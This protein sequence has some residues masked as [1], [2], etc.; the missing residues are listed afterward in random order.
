M[1]QKLLFPNHPAFGGNRLRCSTKWFI[2]G[3][4]VCFAV[5]ANHASAVPGD[6]HWDRQFGMAGNGTINRALRCNGNWLY[7]GGFSV[8]FGGQISSNTVVNVFNGTNW[9]ILGEFSGSTSAILDF[10]FLGSNVYVGGIFTQAG[11]VPAVGLAKWDGA[12]WSDVGGFSGMVQTMTTD[13]TNIYVGGWFTNAGGVHVINVARWNGTNW[14]ALGGGLGSYDDSSFPTVNVLIWRKG[15]LYAGGA[16]ASAGAVAATNLACWDGSAWSQVGG[17]VPGVGDWL[18]GSPVTTLQ[19]LDDD[20]YAGGNFTAVGANVPALHVAKWNG[21]TWSAL[22]TGL[23][24]SSTAPPVTEL[25]FL[26]TNLYAT[27]NF[28]NAGGITATH[29][30]KWNGSAWSSI[31]ALNS[32]GDRAVSNSGSIY[33][34][35]EFNIA[36]GTVIGNH[37]IR[38]DGTNW[39]G[40][41]GKS[42]QGTHVFVYALGLANDGLYMGGLFG[43]AGAAPASR[44]ARWDGTNW[45]ALGAGLTGSF[46]GNLDVRAIKARNSDVYIGG[47]FSGAGAVACTNIAKWS[48]TSWSALAYGLDYSVYA[49]EVT[50]SDVYVGGVF[51]NAWRGP[52]SGVAA[53]RMVRW[54]GSTWQT[55]GSGMNNAVLAICATNGIVYAGGAFTTAGGITANRIARWDGTN[56]S[57]LGTGTANG[58]SSTVYAI[59]VDGTDVY[60]GGAFTT[61]GGVT[62]PGIAKWNGS[63][64]SAVGG[65]VFYSSTASVRSLAKIG[66]YLYAT[67]VFTNAGGTTPA[68]F[69]ARWNGTKWEALGNGIGTTISLARGFALVASGNDLFV[70]GVFEDAGGGDAGYVARWNDQIDFT[71]PATLRLL[72]PKMLPGNAFKFRATAT[73]RAAYV[74]EHTVDFANWTPLTT[75]S[76]SSLTVTNPAPGVTVRA[77]RMREIP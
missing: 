54:D 77:Y 17:G 27:G 7:T 18:A 23:K 26:G 16:F 5:L 45:Y 39:Y 62:A 55:L 60:V 67:G 42:A 24:A 12:N 19:F 34:C 61:A 13:G 64:W 57:S 2:R 46:V 20:L 35:G 73:E 32:I 72:N 50:S 70:G 53:N 6:G 43:A 48:G 75:N 74:I 65:G 22:G 37:V 69:I 28:T 52:G 1:N 31:G 63:S 76:L 58:V 15:L 40:V 8:G 9:S 56:W 38:W 10:A 3:G 49:I 44:V 25:A 71:P 14:S 4:V 41:A 66:G 51:T 11:G 36:N 33:F 21:N 30:A 59:L 29:V 47:D 68:N